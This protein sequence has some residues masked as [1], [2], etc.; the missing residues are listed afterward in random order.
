MDPHPSR[1]RKMRK[2]SRKMGVRIDRAPTRS[3]K[4]RSHLDLL[5]QFLEEHE[6]QTREQRRSREREDPGRR[7]IADG[8]K[9]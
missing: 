8:G 1:G 4:I 5:C 3:N 2:F 9:L 6:Q 7:D